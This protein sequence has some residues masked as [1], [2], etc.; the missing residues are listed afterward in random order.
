VKN[1][2]LYIREF[3]AYYTALGA[4]HIFF[5]DNGSHDNTI[6][7]CKEYPQVS[8]YLTTLSFSYFEN[9]IREAFIKHLSSH[10][11]CLYVDIDEFFDYPCSD[12]ISMKELIHYLTLHHYTAVLLQM[13]ILHP[14]HGFGLEER[15]GGK[16]E[17]SI[18]EQCRYYHLNNIE[19]KEYDS[20]QKVHDLRISN[21][22][23]K[24]HLKK[25]EDDYPLLIF[26][27]SFFFVDNKI[28]LF[29]NPHFCRNAHIADMSCLLKHYKI[30]PSCYEQDYP[31]DM[32]EYHHIDPLIESG[33]IV[34]SDQFR[35]YVRTIIGKS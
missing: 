13:L 30:N 6:S 4:K 35:E 14:G 19:K 31:P 3:I 1:G 22:E 2:E 10:R 5:L 20:E 34:I 24:L 33:F 28:H 25:R 12:H 32:C 23:M 15:E 26:K 7:I 21:R 27:H 9:Q 8:I 17:S 29:S 18:I 11:W 16:G